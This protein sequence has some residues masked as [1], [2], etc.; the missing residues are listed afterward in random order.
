[1]GAAPAGYRQG[2]SQTRIGGGP[3]QAPRRSFASGHIHLEHFRSP[4]ADSSLCHCDDKLPGPA[5]SRPVLKCASDRLTEC[6]SDWFRAAPVA[7]TERISSEALARV[8]LHRR[9]HR[10]HKR[11]AIRDTGG[12]DR[13]SERKRN[14]QHPTSVRQ[15]ATVFDV[16]TPNEVPTDL[17][18]QN[19]DTP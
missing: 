5:R 10:R 15:T 16:T 3:S 13:C 6:I 4:A 8:G 17:R 11:D 14:H 12:G 19:R 7:H 2:G 1:M 9:W 18:N